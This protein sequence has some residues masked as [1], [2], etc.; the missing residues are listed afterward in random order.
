MNLIVNKFVK[1]E[2]YLLKNQ[3]YQVQILSNDNIESSF[4]DQNLNK[5]LM[6]TYPTI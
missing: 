1:R 2:K 4:V 3:L 5:Y 6:K